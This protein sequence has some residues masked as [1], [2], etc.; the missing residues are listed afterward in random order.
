MKDLSATILAAA[1]KQMQNDA[2]Y[3]TLIQLRVKELNVVYRLANSDRDVRFGG[4]SAGAAIVW[5]RFPIAVGD[6]RDTKNG[7]LAQ[8]QVGL[9]DVSLELRAL[10]HQYRGFLGSEVKILT[11]N[12]AALSD[13]DAKLLHV[14]EIVDCEADEKGVL[15]SLGQPSLN[16]AVFPGRR[17]LTR[18]GV[19]TFGDSACGYGI[20]TSPTN[21]V[22]GG[23]DFCPRSLAA[24]Q[25]RGDDEVARGLTRGHPRR[26][27]G[28][29]GIA[30]GNE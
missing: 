4:T 2:P 24:C 11:I 22:G 5:Q 8:I 26:M 19:V 10:I 29:P 6:F 7:D 3:L 1:T 20:P 9:A 18:C 14:G 23:F 21:A 27:D 15:F 28:F 25:E 12:A 17:Y 16:D 30:P 13:L